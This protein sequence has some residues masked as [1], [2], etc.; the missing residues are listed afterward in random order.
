[1]T[2]ATVNDYQARYDTTVD[3]ARLQTLLDD[4]SSFIRREAGLHISRVE[5]DTVTLDDTAI[6]GGYLLVLPELPVVS[7]T[8]IVLDGVTV[9]PDTYRVRRWGHVER[10][11]WWGC[12]R[13]VDVTYTH[14]WD[15][16]PEWI[17]ALVCST[18][19]RATRP[20]SVQGVQ[21]VT[22]GSQYVQYATSV[23]GVNLWLT[24]DEAAR[25][26]ALRGATVA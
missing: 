1:M 15:P 3:P 19:Q 8:S 2:L 7:V 11:G 17:V 6:L 5:H 10:A 25:L 13:E 9:D 18:V 12:P 4:A 24:R 14:G 26:H 21:G 16:V 22:T 20:T 23:A